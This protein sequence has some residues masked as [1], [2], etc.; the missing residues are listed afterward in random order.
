MYVNKL[1]FLGK[2]CGIFILSS[3]LNS[4]NPFHLFLRFSSNPMQLL[5]FGLIMVNTYQEITLRLEWSEFFLKGT[6]GVFWGDFLGGFSWGV[7]ERTGL[8]KS[9]GLGSAALHT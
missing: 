8:G 5:L 7:V 1:K 6:L 4:L 2:L 9:S 3:S